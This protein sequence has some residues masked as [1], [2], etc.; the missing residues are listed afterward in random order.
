MKALGQLLGLLA[1]VFGILNGLF[2]WAVKWLL[3][4]HAD[5]ISKQI[6]QLEQMNG[7]V[8]TAIKELERDLLEL[9]AELPEKYLARADW[10]RFSAVIDHKLDGMR[11]L[12]ETVKEKV[13]R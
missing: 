11:A 4:R 9:R 12:L 5:S 13:M 2:F 6:A 10:I 7:T 1:L 8:S 3:D